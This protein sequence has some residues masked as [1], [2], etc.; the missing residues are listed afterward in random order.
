MRA[1][2][3]NFHDKR[4]DIAIPDHP[5]RLADLVPFM[6]QLTNLIIT[7]AEAHNEK[8]VQCGPGCGVCC[9]QLVPISLPEV[10]Y[11][12]EKLS[13][14]PFDQRVVYLHRFET[15]EKH[16]SES[17]TIEALWKLDETGN[18]LAVAKNYFNQKLFCPFLESNSCA[19]HQW[20]PVVCR[21]YNVIS[22]PALCSDPFTNSI[23]PL[24]LS[25]KPSSALVLL[26]RE[27]TG[28]KTNQIPFPL[29]F[30]FFEQYKTI[31]TQS[32]PADVALTALFDIALSR[33]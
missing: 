19:I 25:K 16:L 31:A 24:F 7:D 5:L 23:T 15:L 13:G 12:V 30:D 2:T 3:I 27:L 29:L 18:D 32:W 10:F 1:Y 14:M 20:R 11:I 6:H 33:K 17:G 22:D 21:E 9:C 4:F 8:K 28:L 26:T